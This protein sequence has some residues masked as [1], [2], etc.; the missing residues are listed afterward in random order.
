MRDGMLKNQTDETLRVVLRPKIMGIIHLDNLSRA[1]CKDL[2]WF[3]VFSS[4]ASS[5]GNAGQI[6]YAYANSFMERV[7]EQRKADG[8]PGKFLYRSRHPEEC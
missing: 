4:M 6:G 8:F 2:E 7:C 5:R 3:V 1:L